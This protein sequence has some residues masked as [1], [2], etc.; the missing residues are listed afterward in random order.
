MDSNINNYEIM[1]TLYMYNN[2][3][4]LFDNL[5]LA[6]AVTSQLY[7]QKSEIL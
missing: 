3:I 5:W 7:V 2:V 6:A 4:I 1:V